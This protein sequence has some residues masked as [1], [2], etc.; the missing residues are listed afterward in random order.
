MSKRSCEKKMCGVLTEH[1]GHLGSE[2]Q[3][4]NKGA[5]AWKQSASPAQPS[6]IIL[7]LHLGPERPVGWRKT[8]SGLHIPDRVCI[9][10]LCKRACLHIWPPHDLV[11]EDF[12]EEGRF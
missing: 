9:V 3:C 1:S 4:K 6:H 5:L 2:A 7:S 12:I 10:L 11:M 8:V